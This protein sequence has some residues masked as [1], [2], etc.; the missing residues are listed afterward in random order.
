MQNSADDLKTYLTS[1]L[2]TQLQNLKN[3]KDN[4]VAATTSLIT[5]LKA[6]MKA[7]SPLVKTEKVK[8]IPAIWHKPEKLKA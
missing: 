7:M 1:T 8:P 2:A 5:T 4:Q 3:S 6:K